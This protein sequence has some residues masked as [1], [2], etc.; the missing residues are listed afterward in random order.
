M[1]Y[2]TDKNKCNLIYTLNDTPFDLIDKEYR[3]SNKYG[4]VDID[5]FA[6]DYLYSH[7]DSSLRIKT[8]EVL[9]DDN[10]IADIIERVEVCREYVNSLV[11]LI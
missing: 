2:L 4:E 7:L 3:F 1:N 9:R 11:S 5:D 8:F 6:K 10:M